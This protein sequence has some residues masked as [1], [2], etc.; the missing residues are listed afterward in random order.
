MNPQSLRKTLQL[1][2][3]T[4]KPLR[5]HQIYERLWAYCKRRFHLYERLRVPEAV[6]GRLLHRTSLLCHDSWNSSEGIRA[7]TF[8]FLNQPAELG[9]PVRWDK[10]A[11]LPLLWKFNLH[12]FHFLHLLTVPEQEYLCLDWVKTFPQNKGEAWHPYPTSLRIVEWIKSEPKHPAIQRS[13]Y[14]QAAYLS[15]NLETYHPGNHLLENAQALIFAGLYFSGDPQASQWLKAGIAIITKQTPAQVLQDGGY[16]ERSTMYYSLMLELYLNLLNV[17]PLDGQFRP[18]VED[19]ARKML[20]FLQST[21]HPDGQ[22]AL[23]NDSTLEIAP[24]PPAL[25]DYADRLGIQ[26]G[27]RR[28]S[29]PDSGYFVMQDSDLFAIVDCGPIGPDH[30]PAHSHADIFSFELSLGC[31]HFVTDTGVYEYAAGARRDYC[32]ST[33]AHNT[34]EIDGLSQAEAWSSFRVARRFKPENVE[35]IED[36]SGARLSGDFA[37]W[38]QL[39]GE[40]LVHQRSF[41]FLPGR[42][43]LTVKDRVDR[44]GQHQ[45]VSRIHLAPGCQVEITP[46]GCSIRKGDWLLEMASNLPPSVEESPFY[47]RFGTEIPRPVLVFRSTSSVDFRLEIAMTWKKETVLRG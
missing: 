35:F 2:Y 15:K 6:N 12:Y 43:Q 14:E 18:L 28:N 17:L 19:T 1:Y 41:E 29:F 21:L 9:W 25:V 37:G 13:I 10:A 46:V 23:F 32:R 38:G 47:P 33:A 20:S 44:S 26:P 24:P 5:P 4:L 42:G 34:L 11:R 7:G 30:L 8:V 40:R 27:P 39:L 16:F 36:A 31:E 22:L 45:L 3:H